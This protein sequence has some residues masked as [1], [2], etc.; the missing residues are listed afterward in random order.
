M[1]SAHTHTLVH[2]LKTINFRVILGDLPIGFKCH[3]M[4]IVIVQLDLLETSKREQN[5]TIEFFHTT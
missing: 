2:N 4:Y 5:L 1:I 3:L